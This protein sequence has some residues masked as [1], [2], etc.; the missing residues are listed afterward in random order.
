[1]TVIGLARTLAFEFGD[2][3]VTV[4]LI[5]RERQKDRVSEA[6]SRYRRT[7]WTSPLNAR[8]AKCSLDDTALETLVEADYTAELAAFP[9]SERG[10]HVTAQDIKVGGGTAW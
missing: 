2:V 5:C 3:D 10:R 9:A 8:N 4:N 1:M 7:E 6:S